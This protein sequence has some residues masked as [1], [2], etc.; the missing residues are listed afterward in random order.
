LI[1]FQWRNS[2]FIPPKPE[3][4]A[5]IVRLGFDYGRFGEGINS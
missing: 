2:C 3:F 1:V 4:R 5:M